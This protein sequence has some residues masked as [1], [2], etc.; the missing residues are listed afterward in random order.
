VGRV[1]QQTFIDTYAKVG[2][3]KL[4]DR[5][6][7]LTAAELLND[8]VVPFHEE[9]GIPLS[10]VL[11]DR[12]PEYC[13]VPSAFSRPLAGRVTDQVGT[14]GLVPLPEA[15]ITVVIARAPGQLAADLVVGG[16]TP[17]Q[18]GLEAPSIHGLVM[19]TVSGQTVE[20]APDTNPPR[21]AGRVD[22]LGTG[23]LHDRPGRGTLPIAVGQHHEQ[24][25]PAPQRILIQD[26]LVLRDTGTQSLLNRTSNRS[27]AQAEERRADE[28]AE[29]AG[30]RRRSPLGGR[31]RSARAM[32][33]TMA[34]RQIVKSATAPT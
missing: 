15:R 24:G 13:G 16:A 5:K 17:G 10:R 31:G 28:A 29:D 12:G 14:P 22:A 9:H 27:A 21:V 23:L 1:Y 33:S 4:Y 20:L 30:Q 19:L 11:T 8:R 32:A 26:E 18:R 3:A 25:A 6:T 34:T 7:P 2:F